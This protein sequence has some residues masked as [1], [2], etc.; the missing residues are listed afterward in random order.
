MKKKKITKEIIKTICDT[1]FI[2]SYS[3]LHD[4]VSFTHGGYVVVRS[5]TLKDCILLEIY[6]DDDE[7]NIRWMN[8]NCPLDM[9]D[10]GIISFLQ[11][12]LYAVNCHFD[13]IDY[14]L[15]KCCATFILDEDDGTEE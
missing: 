9:G 6:V 2:N 12:V 14:N 13:L 15:E 7:I 3:P 10:D 11:G 8:D 5:Q 1:M 4:D